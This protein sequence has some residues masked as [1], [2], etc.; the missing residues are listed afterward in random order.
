MEP[1]LLACAGS[2]VTATEETVNGGTS[3]IYRGKQLPEWMHG[4]KIWCFEVALSGRFRKQI[5]AITV[6]CVFSARIR[7]N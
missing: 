4:N 7:R 1:T 3:Y 5:K 6:W 2:G